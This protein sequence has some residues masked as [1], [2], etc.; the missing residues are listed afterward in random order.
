MS[1]VTGQSPVE[2]W[3]EPCCNASGSPVFGC[4]LTRGREAKT[5]VR[6]SRKMCVVVPHHLGKG[7]TS[8]PPL[9]PPGQALTVRDRVCASVRQ[10]LERHRRGLRT[11]LW[12]RATSGCCITVRGASK[13]PRNPHGQRF[14]VGSRPGR[15][16]S[17]QGPIE[18]GEDVRLSPLQP[19]STRGHSRPLDPSIRT[20]RFPS[21][22]EPDHGSKARRP[23]ISRPAIRRWTT[24][25]DRPWMRYYFVLSSTVSFRYTNVYPLD[26]L[27]V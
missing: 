3:P 25:K 18:Q 22:P 4:G 20:R 2:P 26:T 12:C 24:A 1:R 17:P 16:R 19:P 5:V 21:P 15:I 23:S 8:R 10:G 11:P 27:P 6:R 13:L 9:H 14:A 7:A